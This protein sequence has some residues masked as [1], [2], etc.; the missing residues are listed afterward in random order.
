MG[1]IP[2]L[3]V[4]LF[5]DFYG[6]SGNLNLSSTSSSFP[7]KWAPVLAQWPEEVCL[8][9]SQGVGVTELALGNP[10]G[11]APIPAGSLSGMG[12]TGTGLSPCFPPFLGLAA[13]CV[14]TEAR[15][16]LL[17]LGVGGWVSIRGPG[18]VWGKG[19]LLCV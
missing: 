11:V 6:A 9:A 18:W 16:S 2:Y 7:F 15:P 5:F 14:F 17:P 1:A 8:P 3:A 12:Q 19:R 10:A 4:P 13:S